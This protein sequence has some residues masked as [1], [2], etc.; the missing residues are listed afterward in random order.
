MQSPIQY[1]DFLITRCGVC[2]C[3]FC[4]RRQ[5]FHA[6]PMLG[7]VRLALKASGALFYCMT[8]NAAYSDMALLS[9]R[10][11]LFRVLS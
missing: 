5:D 3:C 10:W 8:P 1:Y 4:A 11:L 7:L 6:V 2:Y 9:L